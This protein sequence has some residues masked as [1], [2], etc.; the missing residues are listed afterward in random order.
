[1]VP[2]LSKINF[3]AERYY[4]IEYKESPIQVTLKPTQYHVINLYSMIMLYC[5]TKALFELK[6]I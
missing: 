1:M 5:M 4:L 3:T 6:A 2:T